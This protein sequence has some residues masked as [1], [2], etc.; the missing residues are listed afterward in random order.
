MQFVSVLRHRKKKHGHPSQC[1]TGYNQ[2]KNG[3]F[4]DWSSEKLHIAWPWLE[5]AK[6][7]TIKW[8]VSLCQMTQSE[9]LGYMH[10]LQCKELHLMLTALQLRKHG[11]YRHQI[12]SITEKVTSFILCNAILSSKREVRWGCVYSIWPPMESNN[13]G[14]GGFMYS[15]DL[16]VTG[17]GFFFSSEMFDET[18]GSHFGAMIWPSG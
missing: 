2:I 5:I 14:K 8:E 12:Y 11:L 10:A 9:Q 7:N 18:L 4:T 17:K 1:A 13:C 6:L 15:Q 3:A 16:N